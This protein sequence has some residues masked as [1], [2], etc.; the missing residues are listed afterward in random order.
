MT[1]PVQG[2]YRRN[3]GRSAL[4]LL[5]LLELLLLEVPILPDDFLQLLKQRAVL[6]AQLSFAHN[7]QTMT[8]RR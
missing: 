3:R 6:R 7:I 1:L 8:S 2:S 5:L 4:L